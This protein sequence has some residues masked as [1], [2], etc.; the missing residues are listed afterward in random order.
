MQISIPFNYTPRQYQVPLYN[1]I[2][3]GKKRA[4]AIWHRRAGKDK[5]LINLLAKEAFKRVGIY[6]Y[7]FPTYNQG[8]K[9]FWDGI[10]RNGFRYLNHIPQELREGLPNQQEM[11]IRLVNGSLI[12]VIGTDNIDAIMGTN[13]VG[14]V[15]SE[16]SL[17]NPQAWDLIRPILAE[18]GGWA[19]F[20]YTPRGRNHGYDLYIM[21]QNNP[22]WHCELLTVE[23]TGGV[24]TPAVIQAEREA[25]MSEEMIQ[26]EFYCSFEASLAKCFFAGALDGHEA[27][28]S[29]DIGTVT[30]EGGITQDQGGITEFWSLPY[31]APGVWDQTHY[32]F[33]YC[34]G[35]DI[36][37]G[38]GGDWSRAYVFDRYTKEFVARMSSNTIDSYRWAD[39]LL[40]LSRLFD[41]ALIVPERN[42]A[43]ITTVQHLIELRANMYVKE[44]LA[45]VQ[46]KQ[47]TKQYGWLETKE[48]KQTAVGY[49]K[50]YLSAQ[51]DNGKRAHKVYD[52][53]LLQE[54]S[55]FIKDEETG[56]M[57]ADVGFHDDCVIA[58]A[59]ALVGDAYLPEV[60]RKP[61][62]VKLTQAQKHIEK[63]QNKGKGGYE[64]VL[65]QE[66]VIQEEF[67][68][69]EHRR[70]EGRIY[71]DVD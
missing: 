22:E 62:P 66:A 1:C 5:T 12:Q 40:Q 13:P 21:A 25:G 45:G 38:L 14:C 27:V 8:R 6:Y 4:V 28:K 18:N 23:D 71:G 17:Q 51:G 48:S 65:I 57:G 15:F 20:N 19:V 39:K 30:D 56:K 26:Q 7:L 49:L 59:L 68:Y 34:I 67:L 41:N 55:V 29:G 11:K 46:G 61:A 10:D 42:G 24:V 50:S 16:Y 35:S 60:E 36:S 3:N 54:C 9:V 43:G 69:R 70:M 37:E 63:Q 53:L 64:E 2:A 58:A 33:R 31:N 52:K 47:V 44:V 32:P